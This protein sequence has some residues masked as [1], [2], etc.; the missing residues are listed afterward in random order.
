MKGKALWSCK[1]GDLYAYTQ[2]LEQIGLSIIFGSK[3]TGYYQIKKKILPY[4]QRQLKGTL[5]FEAE[6]PTDSMMLLSHTLTPW[7]L[8]SEDRW[9][10]Q[11]SFST[12]YYQNITITSKSS[13]TYYLSF[14]N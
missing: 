6:V 2:G 1:I 12:W 14:T 9:L 10:G 8:P 7:V 3:I 13:M 4:G 11:D 5:A